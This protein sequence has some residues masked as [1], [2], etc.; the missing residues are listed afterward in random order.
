MRA[1]LSLAGV[2]LFAAVF[3]VGTLF[4]IQSRS[5]RNSL[6]PTCGVTSA[7][8]EKAQG[9][10]VQL[11][12]KYP[13]L[14][15]VPVGRVVN[16]IHPTSSRQVAYAGI[17]LTLPWGGSTTIESHEGV[18]TQ[19]RSQEGPFVVLVDPYPD[20]NVRRQFIEQAKTVD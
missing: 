6:I 16:P 14:D 11:Y 4:T 17:T 1:K 15:E 9:L 20:S 10:A 19:I 7:A 2:L 13:F 3:Y 5:Q 8:A 18:G 12:K